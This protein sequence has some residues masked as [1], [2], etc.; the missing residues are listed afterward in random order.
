MKVKKA[1]KI[2]IYPNRH[3]AHIL[4]SSFGAKRFWWNHLVAEGKEYFQT[5][6]QA[7]KGE[8]I[9]F[10]WQTPALAKKQEGQEWMRTLDAHV[11]VQA[12]RD[13]QQAWKNF[14]GNK[15]HF[16]IPQ[17]KK[18]HKAKL[19]YRTPRNGNNLR[20]E[21]KLLKAPKLGWVKLAEELRFCG[22]LKSATFSKT[23]SG[24]YFVSLLVEF[25]IAPLPPVLKKA[26]L[27]VGLTHF[28]TLSDGEKMDNPRFLVKLEKQLA[29]AQKIL[30]RR[31]RANIEKEI[32]YKKGKKK[33][34]LKTVIYKRP[35]SEC[36]NYQKQKKKV[37]RLHETIA[38]QRLDFLHQLTNRLTN[39]NQV[40]C[41]EHLAVANMM[42]N[43]KLAKAIGD[44]S[45]AKFK[46]LLEY[47]AREKGRT[48]VE[49]DRWFPS[50]KLCHQCGVKMKKMPL[51]I[52]EWT[53]PSC[54][55]THDRDINAAIN[56][57][58]EGLRILKQ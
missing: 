9:I 47:K 49:V 27:D 28:V 37:A 12:E 19:S 22:I 32:Y 55:T 50:S 35:L 45:W 6:K 57:L 51:K 44:V 33:G 7:P 20:V 40:L 10:E 21:G 16:G 5:K 30:S 53:C 36:A 3:Q 48:V 2:R 14:K 4:D 1:H 58:T 8:D 24:K 29:K 31:R 23:K 34:Q 39:E 17:F 18:K 15:K 52:R 56:L 25:D 26:G 11:F 54:Q 43:H 38:N 41:I 46:E 42:K 13:Y